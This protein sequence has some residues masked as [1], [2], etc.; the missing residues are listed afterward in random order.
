MRLLFG[1]DAMLGRGV[2]EIIH[3]YGADYPLACLAPL[4]READVFCVNLECAITARRARY[5]GPPK[6]FYFR[7]D[8]PAADALAAAAVGV[9]SLANNHAL[10]AGADGLAD[11]L[12]A[13]DQRGIA[14]AGA[15][16]DLAA[17]SRAAE[18]VRRGRRLGMLAYCDH[19]PDFAAGPRRP[20]IRYVDL[21]HPATAGAVAAEVAALAA[22]VDDVV[23]ALHWQPN[24][25]PVVAPVYRSLAG[26]LVAAGARIIWG[27]SPHHFQ[28]V[29][30]IGSSVVL[31]SCGDLVTDYAVD[32]EF[33][34]DRQVLF[35]VDL[36]AGGVESVSAVPIELDF[37]RV[38]QA[39]PEARAWIRNRLTELC[40][41]MGSEVVSGAS[42]IPQAIFITRA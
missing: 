27:H 31:Y 33:R 15:G 22:R 41:S 34:N 28:G 35:Q 4:A 37:G 3:R 42:T 5:A 39:G 8:P 18:L 36:G 26:R 32:P 40:T 21:L 19:Q 11:T 12:Q 30:R 17:A 25:A 9:V 24:W 20:G 6:A 38:R 2:N 1:G 23:V 7:G 13:L 29:E 10:D 16:M 14:H